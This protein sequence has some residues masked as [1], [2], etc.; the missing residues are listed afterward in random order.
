MKDNAI[1]A[2]G[3]VKIFGKNKAKIK[4]VNGV[5]LNVSAGIVYGVLGPNGAGKTTTINMLTTLIKPDAGTAK[6]FGYDIQKNASSVRQ[7]IGVTGQFASVDEKLSGFENLYIFSKL[8]GLSSKNAKKRANEL[9]EQ[10]SLSDVKTKP[11]SK[12]SGGMR[13]RLDLA[14]S[15]IL[16]PPLVFLDEPTT[17]LDPRTRNQMWSVIKNMVKNGSTVL[18]TTQYLEEAEQLASRIAIIDKGKVVA[19]DTP[20]NLINKVKGAKNLDDVFFELTGE[21]SE[22]NNQLRSL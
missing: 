1:V 22:N 5:D 18:L 4:A 16:T 20:F 11:I 12:F 2:N 9:L 14:S 7:L 3:L 19:E 6:I 15:L 21:K 10:F 17:G 8:L 13:R